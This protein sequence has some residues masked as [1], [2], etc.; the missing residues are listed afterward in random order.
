MVFPLFS[1]VLS[2]PESLSEHLFG[3]I[4]QR[5]DVRV[6]DFSEQVFAFWNFLG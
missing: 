6:K 2:V 3:Y 5:T 1:L 4:L